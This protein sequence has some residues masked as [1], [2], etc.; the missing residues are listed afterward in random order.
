VE[1]AGPKKRALLSIIVENGWYCGEALLLASFYFI[2]NFRYIQLMVTA[3]EI[4]SLFYFHLVP[5]SIRW[6]LTKERY[7][8]AKKILHEAASLKKKKFRQKELDRRIDSLIEHFKLKKLE[9]TNKPEDNRFLL[10]K[11]WSIP[12]MFKLCKL[13]SKMIKS[14]TCLRQ[15]VIPK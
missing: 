8:E 2:S 3:F 12:G 14:I 9:T 7:D 10:F 11:L 1:N 4:A 15:F 6:L 13:F 5:E